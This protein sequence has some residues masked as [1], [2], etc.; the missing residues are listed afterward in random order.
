M[1]GWQSWWIGVRAV[2]IAVAVA[3]LGVLAWTAPVSA[4]DTVPVRV[5]FEPEDSDLLLNNRNPG[6]AYESDGLLSVIGLSLRRDPSPPHGDHS[7][8]FVGEF[9]RPT[10]E[11]IFDETADVRSLTFAASNEGRAMQLTTEAFNAA[12]DTIATNARL[13]VKDREWQDISITANET[14]VRVT[15]VSNP[16]PGVRWR[17]DNLRFDRSASFEPRVAPI[18]VP[19]I[20]LLPPYDAAVPVPV[21]LVAQEAQDGTRSLHLD[22]AAASLEGFISDEARI[23]SVR[24]ETTTTDGDTTSQVLCLAVQCISRQDEFGRAPITDGFRAPRPELIEGP[25]RMEIVA[26]NETGSEARVGVDLNGV[27]GATQER[28]N[29]SAPIALEITQG[30][31]DQVYRLYPPGAFATRN[32]QG[33]LPGG[34]SLL[35]PERSMLVRVYYEGNDPDVSG[36][37]LIARFDGPSGSEDVQVPVTSV[38]TGPASAPV[39]VNSF[40]SAIVGS[41]PFGVWQAAETAALVRSNRPQMGMTQNFVIPASAIPNDA[42]SMTVGLGDIEFSRLSRSSPL[43]FTIHPPVR[44]GYNVLV[45]QDPW[46][47]GT[48]TTPVTQAALQVSLNEYS[49]RAAPW[50]SVEIASFQDFDLDLGNGFLDRDFEDLVLETAALPGDLLSD[51]CAAMGWEYLARGGWGVEIETDISDDASILPTMIVFPNEWVSSD[52][53]AGCAMSG[54]SKPLPVGDLSELGEAFSDID[55]INDVGVLAQR[56]AGA[57]FFITA[58]LADTVL[59]ETFHMVGFEHAPSGGGPGLASCTTSGLGDTDGAYSAG[60]GAVAPDSYGYVIANDPTGTADFIVN[61]IPGAITTPAANAFA[62]AEIMSYC[63]SA[64]APVTTAL[65]A[66][67]GVTLNRERWTS[68]DRYRA[69]HDTIRIADRLRGDCP[70]SSPGCDLNQFVRVC[71]KP[72]GNP[73][74]V[75]TANVTQA[76]CPFIFA[77]VGLDFFEGVLQEIFGDEAGEVLTAIFTGGFSLLD[78]DGE[79]LSL[80]SGPVDGLRMVPG[81]GS[82][83]MQWLSESALSIRLLDESGTVI[84]SAA[85]AYQAHDGDNGTTVEGGALLPFDLDDP[86]AASIELVVHYNGETHTILHNDLDTGDVSID[87][88]R[89]D[90]GSYTW[91]VI[92]ES[93]TRTAVYAL[94]PDGR[95]LVDTIE[96]SATSGTLP[97]ARYLIISGT[98]TSTA[99][100]LVSSAQDADIELDAE[101]EPD[102]DN[103]GAND[104]DETTSTSEAAPGEQNDDDNGSGAWGIALVLLAL[105]C[106]GL[107]WR[108]R[109]T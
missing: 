70:A 48:P 45:V 20:T 55:D 108:K 57:N 1:V 31:N 40:P 27:V 26:V 39:A 41:D 35:V 11:L 21:P 42:T 16:D 86:S 89:S 23:V 62:T 107:W 33:L 84:E 9:A 59:H 102:V 83:D 95:M 32:P 100:H 99:T 13:L 6:P 17:F 4:Q 73:S 30:T 29:H 81:Y 22:S 24:L 67:T 92:S 49:L 76:G 98:G 52:T 18:T 65:A 58:D 43:E 56:L 105:A 8:G 96:P 87:G 51:T 75:L 38:V 5:S 12:G 50:S 36:V 106:I 71:T 66:T 34:R 7:L 97:D 85:A 74:D 79:R 77:A 47:L 78:A 54:S 90:D 15:V 104:D 103:S 61:P 10:L 46:G 64:A 88:N 109:R 37:R 69:A 82:P 63:S 60:G 3:M 53:T 94:G 28:Q 101:V 80:F 91:E 2:A 44:V 25:Y 14:I 19:T 93:E 72:P 68:T